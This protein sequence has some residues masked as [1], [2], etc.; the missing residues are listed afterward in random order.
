M[1]TFKTLLLLL[2]VCVPFSF[3]GNQIS[4]KGQANTP[5][6]R[7]ESPTLPV[8]ASF[9]D[10]TI[11]VQFDRNLGVI[12]IEI[13]AADGVT[14]SQTTIDTNTQSV[15]TLDIPQTGNGEQNYEI[16]IVDQDCMLIGDFSL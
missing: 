12:D 13:V 3:A 6:T 8:N 1:K 16:R 9:E 4:L 11:T 2:F 10:R 14:A 15:V 5:H 7:S